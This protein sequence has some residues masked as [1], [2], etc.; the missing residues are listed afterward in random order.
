MPARRDRWLVW[1]FT[2]ALGCYPAEFR[3]RF[4]PAMLRAFLDQV[5]GRRASAGSLAA[6]STALRSLLNTAVNGLGERRSARSRRRHAGRRREPLRTLVQDLRFAIRTARRQP[7]ISLLSVVTLAVGIGSAAAVFSLVDASLVRDLPL[8]A[9]NRLVAVVETVKHTPSQVSWENLLDWK[10]QARSFDALTPFRA[11]SVNLTGLDTPGRIRGGFVTSDFFPLTGVAPARGRGLIAADDQKNA[12]AVVVINHRLW[13]RALGGRSD[14]VGQVLHLNNVAFTVVGVMP[15]GFEFPY[16]GAEAWIPIRFFT[17]TLNRSARTLTVFGR[18]AAGVTVARAQAELD[19]ITN[20][21]AR[22]Y[23]ETNEG[24]GAVIEP[25][26]RWLSAGGRDQLTLI[27]GLVLVLLAAACANVTSL[28]IGATVTRRQEIAV[29]AA[30]GA[31]RLRIARQLFTEQVVIAAAAGALGLWLARIVVPQIVSSPVPLFGLERASVDLRVV[32]FGV[33]MTLA[34]GIASAFVPALHWA[35]GAPADFLR[36]AVRVTGERRLT[37]ARAVL[38]TGQIGVAAVLLATTGLLVKSFLALTQID[39]GFQANRIQSLEYRLPANKYSD[40]REQVIFHQTVVEHAAAIPGVRRAAVVRGLPFSGNGDVV[41]IRTD[42]MTTGDDP[43]PTWF[44]TVSDEY[45]RALA[46]PLLQGRTF[47]ARDNA[48]APLVVVVSKTFADRAWP[49][50]DPVGRDFEVTGVRVR[51]R[52]IGVVGDVRQYNLVDEVLPAVY[53]RSA[54]NPGIFMTLVVQ[55]G[56]VLDPET[57]IGAMRRAVWAVDSDQPVW[58]ERSL[59]SLVEAT[60]EAGRFQSRALATFAGAA[61][62]LVIAGLYGVVSQSVTQ[63]SRE[64]GVRMVLGADR[65]AVLRQILASGLKLTA[66]GLAIGLG[67][68]ALISRVTQQILYRTSPLD[69]APYALTALGLG[70]IAIV[71]CYLPARRAASVDPTIVLRD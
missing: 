22:E 32:V 35:G 25:M 67:A 40:P 57:I 70:A 36:A 45:F 7:M 71:A 44:N 9:P 61:T 58:K 30:L 8:P 12:P 62:L 1:G 54:Q 19:G 38:V 66:A 48:T 2:R 39:P 14:V 53:A 47:D 65:R 24:R 50:E 3:D 21:L 5:H 11:Q 52:V 68:A 55:T 26:H 37:R 20:T 16:D 41:G 64:I 28:Q 56:G 27:F 46:I 23:P 6:V 51:P 18:L 59:A 31:A 4:G 17:G 63:R 34:A 43:R 49:G 42:R 29:R 69:I 10:R 60:L 13:Q 33:A 15:P